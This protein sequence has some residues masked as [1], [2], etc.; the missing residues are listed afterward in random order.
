M[1]QWVCSKWNGFILVSRQESTVYILLTTS[2]W[3]ISVIYLP[4]DKWTGWHSKWCIHYACRQMRTFQ[5][6]MGTG[7]GK[8]WGTNT[9][10]THGHRD[11]IDTRKLRININRGSQMSR[12]RES[13]M[14]ARR[15]NS[16]K[17][18]ESWR[19]LQQIQS[20]AT[21]LSHETTVLP[22]SSVVHYLHHKD[23]C[24]FFDE[25]H[26]LRLGNHELCPPMV[27]QEI[28]QWHCCGSI[29]HLFQ[30]SCVLRSSN[31][32]YSSTLSPH[33]DWIDSY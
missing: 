21:H 8:S 25:Y 16:M 10:E 6:I 32:P 31:R 30:Q 5:R 7:E 12:E 27:A 33:I 11:D 18:C 23:I 29:L 26:K 4:Q 1:R 20:A 28:L 17:E 9:W 14:E 22:P 2:I 19:S 3:Q 13:Q 15:K 24:M